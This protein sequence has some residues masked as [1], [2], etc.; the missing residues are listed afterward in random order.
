ME[1]LAGL[2]AKSMLENGID[3]ESTAA[4]LAMMD[5]YGKLLREQLIHEIVITPYNNAEYFPEPHW[6]IYAE[7]YQFGIDRA[8]EIIRG[9]TPE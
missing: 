5:E 4:V 3:A 7:G 2:T 6:K 1:D 8:I 9:T